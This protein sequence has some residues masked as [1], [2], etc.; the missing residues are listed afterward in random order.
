M[1]TQL[2][3]QEVMDAQSDNLH[4]LAFAGPSVTVK[5]LCILLTLWFAA[6]LLFLCNRQ[7][8]RTIT[9]NGW[10]SPPQGITRVYSG[11]QGVVS[12]LLIKEGDHVSAGQPLAILH[13]DQQYTAT[14]A[15]G[16]S[17]AQ[18]NQQQIN[19]LK[20]KAD[21]AF[22]HFTRQTNQYS[23]TLAQLQ[24]N[25]TLRLQLRHLASQKQQLLAEKVA[26]MK[27]LTGI[28]I[29]RT[30]FD[31][32][33]SEW[34]YASQQVT[35]LDLQLSANAQQQNDTR[36]QL[37][38]VEARYQQTSLELQELESRLLQKQARFTHQQSTTIVATTP[39][40]VS[41]LVVQTGDTVYPNRLLA[42][43][44]PAQSELQARLMVPAYATGMLKTANDVRLRFDAFPY[45]KFGL[46]T[47]QITAVSS[48]VLLPEDIHAPLTTVTEPVSIA[49]ASIDSQYITA[50]GEDIALKPGMTFS[51]DI[52]LS[53]RTLIEWLAEPLLTISGRW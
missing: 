35:E 23:N 14:S 3:R 24:K 42:T 28:H 48:G 29:T 25:K 43:V 27:P 19:L 12:Q 16:E 45:Q 26:R 10:L 53:Q 51:A 37:T 31:T 52:A 18:E 50:Y 22:E 34:L 36:H 13:T 38:Q 8:T 20:Q 1:R 4:S 41:S 49:T 39:G 6:V 32:L 46:Q 40:V 33:F 21:A 15:I 44:V 30:D 5:T 7:Y 2:F 11:N 17:L 47:A 9:V